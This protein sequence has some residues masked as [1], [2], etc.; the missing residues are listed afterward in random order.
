MTRAQVAMGSLND[1]AEDD[2]RR[3]EY[4]KMHA[5]STRIFGT[6]LLLGVAQLILAATAGAE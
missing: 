5:T 2:P 1:V 6:A 4:R 3:I